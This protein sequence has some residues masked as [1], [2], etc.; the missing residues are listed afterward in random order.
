MFLY[1][2][3]HCFFLLYCLFQKH[4]ML[5]LVLPNQLILLIPIVWTI[6]KLNSIAKIVIVKVKKRKILFLL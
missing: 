4:Q 2:L 5:F 1:P 6:S 3:L